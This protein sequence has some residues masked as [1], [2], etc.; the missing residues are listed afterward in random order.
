MALLKKN[1]TVLTEKQ[2][3]VV[4]NMKDMLDQM[5]KGMNMSNVASTINNA[6]QNS[7]MTIYA[8]FP[9]V[10]SS[11]EVKKAFEGLSVY[12]QQMAKKG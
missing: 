4:R 2:T 8:D 6:P 3:D 5:A 1:E 12:A 11:D 10:E 7:N 9:N